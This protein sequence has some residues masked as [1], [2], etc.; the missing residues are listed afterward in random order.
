MH[1][2]D[3]AVNQRADVLLDSI[4]VRHV[5]ARDNVVALVSTEYARHRGEDVSVVQRPVEVDKE[6]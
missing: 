5:V 2:L 4:T 3:V 1:D 6:P